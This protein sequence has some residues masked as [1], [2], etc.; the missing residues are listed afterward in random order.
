M[1]AEFILRPPLKSKAASSFLPTPSA[2][3]TS[4]TSDFL[5]DDE[6]LIRP[7]GAVVSS[8]VDAPEGMRP[9]HQERTEGKAVLVHCDGGVTRSPSIDIAYLMK[10]ATTDN[11]Q[12]MRRRAARNF[13]KAC[14][15]K[16]NTRLFDQELSQLEAKWASVAKVEVVRSPLAVVVPQL[17]EIR[18]DMAASF[19]TMDM[20]AYSKYFAAIVGDAVR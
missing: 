1:S 13:V 2:R 8:V 4:E 3:F 14:R 11:A 15:P 5:V 19:S 6:L 12:S 10:Y 16:C 9:L 18:F 20:E 17:K 7:L